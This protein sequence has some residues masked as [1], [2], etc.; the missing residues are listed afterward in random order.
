MPLK[1]KFQPQQALLDYL[2]E[3][4]LASWLGFGGSKGGAKSGGVRRVAVKRR[5]KHPK[6]NCLILRRVW[7]DVEK[8]HINK[9]WEEFPELHEFYNVQSKVIRLPEKLGQGMIFFDGAETLGDVQRKAY[10]PEFFDLFVDQAEQFSEQELCLLKTICRWPGVPDN[11][12]KFVLTFN[13]GGQGAAFL[14]RIFHLKE[15]HERENP[16]DYGFIQARGWDNIEWSRAALAVDGYTGDC[17]GNNCGKCASCVY[18]SWDEDARFKYYITR[19]QYGQEQNALP[20]HM[21]AGQL[22]GDFKK[23]A[24]Q[25]FSN[26]DEAVMGWDIEEIQFKEHWPM[27]IS[28]DWGYQH[29]TSVHWHAQAGYQAEDGSPKRLVITFRE[30][31]KDHLSERALAEEICA[32]NNGLKILNIWA[33]HD[34]WDSESHGDTKEKAMSAVFRAHGLH[35]MKQANINRVDGWRFLHR[36]IDEG[37]WIITKNCKEALRAI[38]TAIFDEKKQNE[39]ILKTNTTYDDVLDEL[40]YGLYSQFNVKEESWED[41]LKRKAA[42]VHDLTSRNILMMR[43]NS[44]RDRRIRNKGWVNSRSAARHGRYAS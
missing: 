9:M 40:R 22:L 13:P 14:Q 2:V 16:N 29:S 43:L 3:C 44:E 33:G 7:D 6:T 24:G 23:F 26:F 12:C 34:L 41:Q 38:P 28:I 4:A 31:I 36:A 5:I 25:Y 32:W 10:G 21:R 1:I 15:Y 18:Y 11:T 17:N 39:D 30:L 35:T 19:S 27:W 8:N 20:A 37:E 42:H